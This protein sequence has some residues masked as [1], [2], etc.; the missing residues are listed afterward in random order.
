MGDYIKAVLKKVGEKPRIINIEDEIAEYEREI[1]GY[2]ERLELPTNYK[3]DIL[4][5]EEA[6]LKGL[7]PNLEIPEENTTLHGTLIFVAIN[8]KTGVYRTPTGVEFDAIFQYI[9][10]NYVI[11]EDELTESTEREKKLKNQ[12]KDWA[13]HNKKHQKGLPPYY[14]IKDAGNVEK[15]NQMFNRMMGNVENISNI[16]MADGGVG[17]VSFVNGESS[18]IGEG[19]VNNL[20]PV[21]KDYEIIVEKKFKKEFEKLGLDDE[22][23]QELKTAITEQKPDAN[24]GNDIYKFRW[25]PQKW[26]T[27]KS[28]ATRVIYISIVVDKEVYLVKIYPKNEQENLTNEDKKKLKKI[29][30]K[31]DNGV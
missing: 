9:A 28:G 25:A 19:Y 10:E 4:Y 7:K 11:D 26:N 3:V 5:D 16:G 12:L 24:L 30:D 15:G 22:D 20:Q 1:G 14:T 6:I 2:I 23:L 8:M 29:K 17:L 21:P 18:C 31:I 13:K 27:G